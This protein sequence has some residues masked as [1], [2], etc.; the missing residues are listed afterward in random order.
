MNR[1]FS[2]ARLFSSDV[3]IWDVSSVIAMDYMFW[4]AAGFQRKLCRPVWLQSKA[5]KSDMFTGSAGSISQIVCTA[6]VKSAV[7]ACL[8]LSPKGDCPNGAHGPIAEWDVSGVTNM[9]KIFDDARSFNGDISNWQ[10]T[11]ATSMSAMFGVQLHL[12]V[13][14]RS[15]I[16]QVWWTRVP[17]SGVL[18]HSTATY[19]NGTC[20]VLR[21]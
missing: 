20:P 14:S 9:D 13:T 2:D 4:N 19:R 16:C 18:R 7:V 15:G 1:M 3:S 17:C 11:S 6:T 10:V 12:T 8:K 5:S 21:T